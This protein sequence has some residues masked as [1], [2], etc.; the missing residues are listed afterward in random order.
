MVLGHQAMEAKSKLSPT[1][2]A[3]GADTMSDVDA[4]DPGIEWVRDFF[5]EHGV[6]LVRIASANLSNPS[7]VG[8]AEDVVAEVMIKLVENGDVRRRVAAKTKPIAYVTTMV[9]NKCIDYWRKQERAR[10]NQPTVPLD[11]DLHDDVGGSADEVSDAVEAAEAIRAVEDG[12]ASLTDR[13]RHAITQVHLRE[14]TC[15]EVAEELGVTPQ[16]VSK[17]VG[18]ALA[19]LR[20]HPAL[21]TYSSNND[22]SPT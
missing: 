9:K 2:D 14:R 17:S 18:K 10:R 20:D 1:A 22:T 8:A 16:A 6:T 12:M 21:Q 3:Y 11:E 15:A 4:D 5:V 7:A 19:K 13:Q